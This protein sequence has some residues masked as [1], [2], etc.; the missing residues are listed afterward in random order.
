MFSLLKEPHA[1]DAILSDILGDEILL[2]SHKEH[3]VLLYELYIASKTLPSTLFFDPSWREDLLESLR[4]M[5]DIAY[6]NE[7][8]EQRRRTN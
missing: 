6:R 4:N 1:V 3:S 5:A 7:L 2:K 8:I